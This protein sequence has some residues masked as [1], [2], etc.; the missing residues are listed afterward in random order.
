MP[1][2]FGHRNIPVSASIGVTV[3]R[4]QDPPS[5]AS[6]MLRHID[7]AF[8]AAKGAGKAGGAFRCVGDG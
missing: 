3:T 8:Y 1:V 6:E 2:S 5:S 4:P 7:L